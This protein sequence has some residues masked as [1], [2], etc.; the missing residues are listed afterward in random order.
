MA[1]MLVVLDLIWYSVLALIVTRAKQAF[2]E[3]PW[4]KRVERLTGAVLVG[5]GVRLAFETR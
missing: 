5:L 3:G 2:V 1:T 4:M